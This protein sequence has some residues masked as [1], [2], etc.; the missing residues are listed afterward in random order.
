MIRRIFG[1][2]VGVIVILAI[3]SIF[4]N[5]FKFIV[6]CFQWIWW[7]I[8]VLAMW[9]T[10]NPEINYLLSRTPGDLNTIMLFMM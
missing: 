5:P 7:V 8:S 4:G 2:I 10:R 6:W 3:V 1:I 9:M